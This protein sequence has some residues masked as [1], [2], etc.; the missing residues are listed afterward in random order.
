MMGLLS[1]IFGRE[2]PEAR[3]AA[4]LEN[5]AL[6][7]AGIDWHGGISETVA[8]NLSTV[9]AC[10]DAVAG[11]IAAQP[12][13]LRRLVNGS[14]VEEPNSQAARVFRR[15]NPHMTGPD[16]IQTLLASTLLSGNGLLRIEYDG[17]ARPVALWPIPWNAA[18]MVRLPSGRIAYDVV[19]SDVLPGEWSAGKTRRY[20]ED[21]ILHLRDR[22]GPDGIVGVSR[23][24]RARQVIENAAELQNFALQSW[25]NSATPSGALELEGPLSQVQA[26]RLRL[27]FQQR[28]QGTANARSVLL[29]ESGAK[30]RQLSV[31]PEDAEVLASRRFSVEEVARLFGVPSPVVNDLS[32]GTFHNSSEMIRHFAQSTLSH[33]CRK[34]EAEVS[35]S[36]L[37]TG[38]SDPVLEIDLSGLL[39][40]DP[41]TRWR[42]WQ[43]AIKA[44]VLDPDE[45]RQEEGWSRRSAGGAA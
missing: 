1:R 13:T 22:T 25:K 40:G 42:S 34:I 45:V 32:H 17:A 35:R 43:I 19:E 12:I 29:L 3:A 41:E 5:P 2:P 16:L 26:D 30:W 6:H 39:R 4:S 31:S 21:E 14:W 37:G 23:L 15:P 38:P 36:L 44:G 28:H 7:W 18:R 9:S 33:W 10:V 8:Q 20:F 11:T 27:A 24:S